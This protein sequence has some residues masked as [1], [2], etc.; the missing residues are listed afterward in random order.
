M[1]TV[2]HRYWRLVRSTP[3]LALIVA[4]FGVVVVA[5]ID[6]GTGYEISISIFYLG[7]VF[8]AAWAGDCSPAP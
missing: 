5:G 7:P 2:L 6:Y 1:T 8:L 3:K 4:A